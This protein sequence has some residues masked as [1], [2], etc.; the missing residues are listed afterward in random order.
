MRYLLWLL[1][2]LRLY[3]L[4]FPARSRLARKY[5]SG[6]GIEIGALHL[7]LPVPE[8]ARVRYVD[9]AANA[10]LRTCYP[11]LS[12]FRLTPV[13]IVDNGEMLDTIPAVSLDFIIANHF[14]E[15]CENPLKTFMIHLSRLKPGGMLY[16]AVPDKGKTFDKYRPITPIEHLLDDYHNGPEHSRF[17]HYREW[18]R[19]LEQVPEGRVD[20]RARKLMGDRYSI[21]F[22]VWTMTAFLTML[23]YLAHSLKQRFI[24]KETVLSRNEFI[25]VLQK[26]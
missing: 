6:S 4:I 7:P 26:S 10:R 22:H 12:I 3:H 8:R 13:D 23:E 14:Y 17:E 1:L 9:H 11:E 2:N 16:L 5:L 15:H 19:A 24:V 20:D 18:V 21:H 25:V